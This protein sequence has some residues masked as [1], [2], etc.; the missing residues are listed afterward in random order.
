MIAL[1]KICVLCAQVCFDRCFCKFHTYIFCLLRKKKKSNHKKLCHLCKLFAIYLNRYEPMPVECKLLEAN[2]IGDKKAQDEPYFT[3][4]SSF[5][6]YS[7]TLPCQVVV[8][9]IWQFAYMPQEI[10]WMA[11]TAVSI[12]LL[13]YFPTTTTTTFVENFYFFCCLCWRYF[14]PFIDKCYNLQWK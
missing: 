14:L 12:V 5:S 7:N 10:L 8:Q 13:H 11:C 9:Y 6:K 4:Q 3:F 2:V 1:H